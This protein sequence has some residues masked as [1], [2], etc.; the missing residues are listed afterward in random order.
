MDTHSS[1]TAILICAGEGTRW[2]NYLG[3]PKHLIEIEGETL[4]SRTVR[5]LNERGVNNINVV[6][7]EKDP[8]YQ[9]AGSKLFIARLN[10]EQN[11][12]ADKF[13]SSKSLWSNE[14]RTIV[15]YGD[16]YFTDDAI[17]TIL[18]HT[19]REWTLF[20]RPKYS[21]ITGAKWPE[22][23][24]QSFYPEHISKHEA[25]L[26]KIAR[27]YRDGVISRC[28]G[29]EHYRAVQG[30]AD[31]DLEKNVMASGFV[32]IDDWT[33]DFDFPEDYDSWIDHRRLYLASI[34][35]TGPRK[36]ALLI[37]R[38]AKKWTRVARR[39]VNRWAGRP[40]E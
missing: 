33:E 15:L 5:L 37:L 14:G 18:S 9:P 19:R 16:C 20:C 10:Y 40:T 2:N 6:A 35:S 3:I 21:Q 34:N 26:H 1:I 4:I 24:A 17:D 8:S 25:A 29:W 22:C 39:M 38:E 7:K 32:V 11:A 13:L 30:V 36:G 31:Q 27:L 12:D 23:F 28:G